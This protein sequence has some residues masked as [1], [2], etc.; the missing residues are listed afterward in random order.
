MFG[1]RTRPDFATAASRE[2]GVRTRVLARLRDCAGLQQVEEASGVR[3]RKIALGDLAHLA[4][5][6]AVAKAPAGDGRRALLVTRTPA[7]APADFLRGWGVR[8][9]APPCVRY[10]R[11]G[12]V[13]AMRRD[14]RAGCGES[15]TP[16]TRAAKA[17]CWRDVRYEAEARPLRH[18]VGERRP[19]VAVVM[20]VEIPR[21][22][23]A[24]E[25][26]RGVRRCVC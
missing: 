19:A 17:R 14:E 18:F 26:D 9:I 25:Q 7:P 4:R 16:H 21:G 3:M 20:G 6:L 11:G 12:T 15:H 24:R 23:I 13:D 2:C 10:A 1:R 5:R 22:V 8:K